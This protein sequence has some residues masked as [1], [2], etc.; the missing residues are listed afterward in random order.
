MKALFCSKN[1]SH[2][3][4]LLKNGKKFLSTF[5]KNGKKYAH[6]FFLRKMH[7]RALCSQPVSGIGFFPKVNPLFKNG[8]KK[9]PK[10]KSQNTFVQKV[11]PF[12]DLTDPDLFSLGYSIFVTI[13]AVVI[14][15]IKTVT[16][17]KDLNSEP[18]EDNFII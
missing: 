1:V 3:K 10:T 14:K 17:H 2:R 11:M 9:C 5:L 8:Q 7:F 18:A 4:S 12:C 13:I 6:T 15:I 16:Q